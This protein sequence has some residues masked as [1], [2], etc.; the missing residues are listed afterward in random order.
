MAGFVPPIGTIRLDRQMTIGCG[1]EHTPRFNAIGLLRM[2]MG[3]NEFPNNH[4]LYAV[5]NNATYDVTKMDFTDIKV[6]IRNTCT[7]TQ[8][9]QIY[10]CIFSMLL[11]LVLSKSCKDNKPPPKD[12]KP[13]GGASALLVCG[14]ES[15][16]T[17]SNHNLFNVGMGS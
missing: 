15:R 3:R 6:G 17:C 5:L 7:N 9:A 1:K 2:I 16:V 10:T 8:K 4:G 13:P 14:A 11:Q 12:K